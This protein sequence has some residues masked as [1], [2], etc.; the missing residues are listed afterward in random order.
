MA[1]YNYKKGKKRL[2]E[3][4]YSELSIIDTPSLPTDE[5]ITFFKGYHCWVTSIFVDIR[6]SSKLF[7][8][9]EEEENVSKIIKCFSSEIISIL[10]E[11]DNL[12]EIGI[13][14]DCVYAIYTTPDDDDVYELAQK[15]FYINTFIFMLNEL[16][17]T[18]QL[19]PIEVG[20]G[21]STDNELVVSACYNYD[22]NSKVW[23]GNAVSKA[24]NLSS[25]GSK[26]GN[27]RIVFSEES[28]KK[29]IKRLIITYKDKK[30]HNW[31]TYNCD[32]NGRNGIY[33]TTS[34][35]KKDF[36]Q[37]IKITNSNQERPEFCCFNENKYYKFPYNHLSFLPLYNKNK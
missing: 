23:I 4:I 27:P 33:Y 2:E 22:G 8:N 1:K 24:S 19:A 12:R 31:F 18:A 3:I 11:D 10:K 20:I 32:R 30:P 5:D 14:G 21:M 9:K 34:I 6:D 17:K 36:K 29:I 25:I 7:H 28:Y 37:W 35:F 15:T 16:L 13:R 26:N